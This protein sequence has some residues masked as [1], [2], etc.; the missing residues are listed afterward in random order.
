MLGEACS[1]GMAFAIMANATEVPSGRI[2]EE[3]VGTEVDGLSRSFEAPTS[4]RKFA[5]IHGTVDRDNDIGVFRNGLA[6]HQTAHECNAQN[7][8]TSARSPHERAHSEQE[9]AARFGY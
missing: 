1:A 4:T 5:Q 6:C 3:D 9:L 8:W 7:L 2:G